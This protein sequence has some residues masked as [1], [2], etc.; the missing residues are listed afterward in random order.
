ME[1]YQRMISVNSEEKVA[2]RSVRAIQWHVITRT[3]HR[4]LT[5][6]NNATLRVL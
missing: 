3:I 1:F 6:K 5:A 4:D 2:L